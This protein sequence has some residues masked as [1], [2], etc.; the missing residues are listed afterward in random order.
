MAA[1]YSIDLFEETVELASTDDDSYEKQNIQS[2]TKELTNWYVSN[3]EQ[4]NNKYVLY[5]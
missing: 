1:V 5:C 2:T 3:I 4:Q